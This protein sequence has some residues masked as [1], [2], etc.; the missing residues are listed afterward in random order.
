MNHI[1][2][3]VFAPCFKN[4]LR[5]LHNVCP[6]AKW[7]TAGSRQVQALDTNGQ[8]GW[9]CTRLA[10]SACA[11]TSH[12]GR[13]KSSERAAIGLLFAVCW[14]CLSFLAR[15]LRFLV[16]CRTF[17]AEAH[18]VRRQCLGSLICVSACEKNSLSILDQNL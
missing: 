17:S 3:Y 5:V 15:S 9:L 6:M 2:L 4:S 7:V 13:A 10:V 14:P 11:G 16:L 8:A 1:F 12:L 18:D